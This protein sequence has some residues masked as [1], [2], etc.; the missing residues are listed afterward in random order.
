MLP[1]EVAAK[2][3]LH[4]LDVL[5]GTRAGASMEFGAAVGGVGANLEQ[6]CRTCT[7]IGFRDRLP[8]AWAALVNGR[9]CAHGLD[10]E[11]TESAVERQCQAWFPRR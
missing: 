11:S 10:Y 1:A 4:L 5:G 8:A 7:V 3:K 6:S 9:R 2:V